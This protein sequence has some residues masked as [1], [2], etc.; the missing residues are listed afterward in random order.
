MDA[1]PKF[2][3]SFIACIFYIL[4]LIKIKEGKRILSLD[5]GFS[6]PGARRWL[7]DTGLG[8]HRVTSNKERRAYLISR[9]KDPA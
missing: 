6:I 5:T 3:S 7:L 1:L 9:T 8:K 4:N 2:S